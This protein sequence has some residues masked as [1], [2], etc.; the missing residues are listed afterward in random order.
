MM[1]WLP[2]SLDPVYAALC[3]HWLGLLYIVF[4]IWQSNHKLLNVLSHKWQLTIYRDLCVV[5]VHWYAKMAP[6]PITHECVTTVC[7]RN[8]AIVIG[9]TTHLWTLTPLWHGKQIPLRRCHDSY[10]NEKSLCSLFT[11]RVPVEATPHN[12]PLEILTVSA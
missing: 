7:K 4:V 5:C 11:R 12:P 9:L 1:P 10:T 6:Q 8:V 3:V 2:T